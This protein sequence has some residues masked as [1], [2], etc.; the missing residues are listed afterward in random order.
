MEWNVLEQILKMKWS[1]ISKV[2]KY[3]LFGPGKCSLFPQSM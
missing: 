3:S 1:M 2:I